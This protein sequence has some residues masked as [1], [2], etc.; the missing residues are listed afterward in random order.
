[1]VDIAILASQCVSLSYCH[2]Q[3]RERGSE[4]L[5]LVIWLCVCEGVHVRV[6]IKQCMFQGADAH[7]GEGGKTR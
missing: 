7:V 4:R 2:L 1:M 6:Q 5:Q 3:T